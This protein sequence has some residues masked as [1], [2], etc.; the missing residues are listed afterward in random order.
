MISIKVKESMLT[1]GL[2][3]IDSYINMFCVCLFIYRFL[4]FMNSFV[5]GMW[6]EALD[7]A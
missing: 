3:L 4:V 2:V 6:G 1:G 5:K 7:S